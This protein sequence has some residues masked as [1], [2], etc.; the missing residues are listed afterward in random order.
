MKTENTIEYEPDG[1][2]ICAR[3][4]DF[5]NLQVSPAGFGVTE[6]RALAELI[7][8]IKKDARKA[9]MIEAAEICAARETDSDFTVEATRCK[10]KILT[11]AS[12]IK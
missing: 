7:N 6:S 1:D 10:Q 8:C 4:S 9:G 3:L 12:Q 11:A 5:D 2:M